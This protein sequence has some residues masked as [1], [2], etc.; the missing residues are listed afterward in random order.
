MGAPGGEI[1]IRCRGFRP[2]LPHRSRVG[3]GKAEAGI[4]TASED[5]VV[6]RL[7]DSPHALGICLEVNDRSSSLFPF[8]TADTDS[9]YRI[10]HSWGMGHVV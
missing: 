9:L 1:T 10:Q 6:V 2:G 4:V 7:P 8:A 3:V 5:K